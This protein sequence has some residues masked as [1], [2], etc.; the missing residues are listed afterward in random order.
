MF[1]GLPH[2]AFWWIEGIFQIL[3]QVMSRDNHRDGAGRLE[4]ERIPRP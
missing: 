4:V 1:D 2:L 3:Q